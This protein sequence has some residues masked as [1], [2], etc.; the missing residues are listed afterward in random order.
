LEFHTTE[1]AVSVDSFSLTR[2]FFEQVLPEYEYL[3]N[4][5]F[6]SRDEKKLE[7]NM[8]IAPK[9]LYYNPREES[10]LKQLE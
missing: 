7:S 3:C 8:G 1:G 4:Q 2:T 10:E 9:Q 6:A 5:R